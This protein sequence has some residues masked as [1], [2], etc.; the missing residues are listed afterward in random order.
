MSTSANAVV[1]PTAPPPKNILTPSNTYASR[2]PTM[3]SDHDPTTIRDTA[4]TTSKHEPQR[5]PS[6]RSRNAGSQSTTANTIYTPASTISSSKGSACDEIVADSEAAGWPAEWWGANVRNLTSDIGHIKDLLAKQ[7]IDEE[8]NVSRNSFALMCLRLGSRLTIDALVSVQQDLSRLKQNHRASLASLAEMHRTEIASLNS[9][10]T[11]AMRKQELQHMQELKDARRNHGHDRD[12]VK[13]LH[14]SYGKQI[15]SLVLDL[16]EAR[17]EIKELKL[18]QPVGVSTELDLDFLSE[19]NRRLPVKLAFDNLEGPLGIAEFTMPH[20]GQQ[21]PNLLSLLS[22]AVENHLKTVNKTANFFISRPRDE[23]IATALN[24]GKWGQAVDAGN[25]HLRFPFGSAETVWEDGEWTNDNYVLNVACWYEDFRSTEPETAQPAVEDTVVSPTAEDWASV[26]NSSVAESSTGKDKVDENDVASVVTQQTTGQYT[27]KDLLDQVELVDISKPL[28]NL[29]EINAE[30]DDLGAAAL[31]QPLAS[32]SEVEL[33]GSSEDDKENADPRKF[34]RARLNVTLEEVRDEDD[35]PSPA[36]VAPKSDTVPILST[37]T[38]PKAKEDDG[39]Q[40]SGNEDHERQGSGVPLIWEEEEKAPPKAKSPTKLDLGGL[41]E[42]LEQEVRKSEASSKGARSMSGSWFFDELYPL[43]P[44]AKEKGKGVEAEGHYIP[45]RRVLP[46]FIKQSTG[47][48]ESLADL[49][50]DPLLGNDRATNNAKWGFVYNGRKETPPVIGRVPSKASLSNHPNP[51]MRKWQDEDD[52]E[53]NLPPNI[54]KHKAKPVDPSFDTEHPPPAP[55]LSGRDSPTIPSYNQQDMSES[56]LDTQFTSADEEAISPSTQTNLNNPFSS[57]AS[58]VPDTPVLQ[59]ANRSVASNTPLLPENS[60]GRKPN[61]SSP[62]HH[63]AF[64]TTTNTTGSRE[65]PPPAPCASSP[66]QRRSPRA[67]RSPRTAGYA[68]TTGETDWEDQQSESRTQSSASDRE[69][70]ANEREYTQN[71]PPPYPQ[72]WPTDTEGP[73]DMQRGPGSVSESEST[74]RDDYFT[75]HQY[76]YGVYEQPHRFPF[77]GRHVAPLGHRVATFPQGAFGPPGFN[78]L[79]D[80][81]QMIF[82]QN[83]SYQQVYGGNMPPPPRSSTAPSFNSGT[84]F[85]PNPPHSIAPRP[86]MQQLTPPY[87]TDNPAV[88]ARFPPQWANHAQVQRQFHGRDQ[89]QPRHFSADGMN[90]VVW[91]GGPGEQQQLPMPVMQQHGPSPSGSTH[92][93]QPQTMGFPPGMSPW[94]MGGPF[95]QAGSPGSQQSGMHGRAQMPQWYQGGPQMPGQEQFQWASSPM[96][97]GGPVWPS[98]YSA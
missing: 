58:A 69:Y 59:E 33:I 6:I 3:A 66:E 50:T 63:R 40:D 89:P 73:L 91:G 54:Q 49:P 19:K 52:T 41:S 37:P 12:L 44:I 47:L 80:P 36:T 29:D 70:S 34:M 15:E 74:E 22:F 60:T 55:E 13:G 78:L 68:P 30:L 14:E 35:P 10:H 42:Y 27:A 16:G 95:T 65:P 85:A 43:P 71:G 4:S 32:E 25:V 45:L 93:Q 7:T 81:T 48:S 8:A 92:E 83:M 53:D 20:P 87:Q 97:M 2:P 21:F 94:A 84:V 18:T 64:T 23:H 46:N 75:E 76:P 17:R 98:G 88:P 96:S 9:A 90:S 24:I 82:Q 62:H 38:P 61:Q 86:S 77:R 5:N 72:G 11:E 51:V 79:Q 39:K 31:H 1:S 67:K 28:R 26:V 56:N 57:G